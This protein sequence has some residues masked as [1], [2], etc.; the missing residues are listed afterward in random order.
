M[1]DVLGVGL[2][3]RRALQKYLSRYGERVFC[4]ELYHQ[5]RL[6]MDDHYAESPPAGGYPTIV[7]QAELK[8]DQIGDIIDYFPHINESLEREYIPDFLLHSPGN[9]RHQKLVI[10]VKSD[11]ELSFSQIRNDLSKIQQFITR[12]LYRMGLF[13]AI[14]VQFEKLLGMVT[15]AENRQWIEESLP[16]RRRILIMCKER[17]GSD[18]LE[19][20][21]DQIP[22]EA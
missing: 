22:P 1:L 12:Y 3:D 2:A 5:I 14:N 21:L 4:Y 18:L 16:N 11:P 10:E 19:F 20:A 15:K 8:K 6:L 17:R 9:F 13:I 7:L